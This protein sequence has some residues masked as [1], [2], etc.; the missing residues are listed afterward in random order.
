M[1]PMEHASASPHCKVLLFNMTLCKDRSDV[2]N[3]TTAG[4]KEGKKEQK[5]NKKTKKTKTNG[6]L[7]NENDKQKQER[8]H[9]STH[10]NNHFN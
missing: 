9:H 2:Q 5:E 10:A 4:Q 1:P 3:E 6:E 7:E 8:S